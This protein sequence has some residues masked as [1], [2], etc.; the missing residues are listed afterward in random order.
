VSQ[1]SDDLAIGVEAVDAQHQLLYAKVGEL[2]EAM[3]AHALDRVP[4]ILGFL[5]AYALRHF[6]AEERLMEDRGY[7]GLAAHRALHDEFTR[8]YLRLKPGLVPV[9]RPSAVVELSDWLGS[10]L[11]DHVRR[12]DGDLGRFLRAQ[13]AGPAAGGSS[14]ADGAPQP[15]GSAEAPASGPAARGPTS[16]PRPS[17][18]KDAGAPSIPVPADPG[19]G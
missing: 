8:E 17:P 16:D 1:W 7:P 12:A 4:A 6:A 19:R 13:G 3:R 2:R 14:P 11:R 5:E 18:P 10:W 15:G 9:P